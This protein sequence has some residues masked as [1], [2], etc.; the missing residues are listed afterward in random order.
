MN[1][2]QLQQVLRQRIKE[3]PR[4]FQ[5][6]LAVRLEVTRA[7]V[8]QWVQGVRPVPPERLEQVLDLLGLELELREKE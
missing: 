8:G 3:Q 5:N 6:A 1:W 7:T 2:E 4:G